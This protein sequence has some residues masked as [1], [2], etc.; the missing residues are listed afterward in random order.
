VRSGQLP[1]K[2]CSGSANACVQSQIS[3]RRKCWGRRP[4][5]SLFDFVPLS[6]A[7]VGAMLAIVVGYLAITEAAKLRVFGRRS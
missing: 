1:G 5:A 2:T 7:L 6:P 4:L 3:P